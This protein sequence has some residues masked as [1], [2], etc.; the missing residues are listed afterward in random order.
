MGSSIEARN[1]HTMHFGPGTS[2]ARDLCGKI[3]RVSAGATGD[4]LAEISP[5]KVRFAPKAA[6]Q[7]LRLFVI[8]ERT[9]ATSTSDGFSSH[10]ARIHK[11]TTGCG[12]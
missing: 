2:V 9:I 11:S 7:F 8:L 4:S 10:G 3:P 12:F 5:M 1:G 6:L